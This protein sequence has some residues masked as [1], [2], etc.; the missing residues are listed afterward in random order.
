MCS[1]LR[2]FSRGDFWGDSG[3]WDFFFLFPCGLV[4]GR[5][6]LT[7]LPSQWM[8]GVPVLNGLVPHSRGV[9]EQ[10]AWHFVVWSC[11]RLNYQQRFVSKG[12]IKIYVVP[13]V[14]EMSHLGW[15]RYRPDACSRIVVSIWLIEDYLKMIVYCA[16]CLCT[17]WS[18]RKLSV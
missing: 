1:L 2:A 16:A 17:D 4:C 6:P 13:G 8:V 5:L 10:L 3:S 12:S 14:W 11:N 18:S 7:H 15:G 9:W